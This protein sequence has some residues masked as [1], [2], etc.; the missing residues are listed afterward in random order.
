MMGKYSAISYLLR[1]EGETFVSHG[2]DHVPTLSCPRRG[3]RILGGRIGR[4]RSTRACEQAGWPRGRSTAARLVEDRGP[5]PPRTR[6][7]GG[8]GGGRVW[9]D[10]GRPRG[11][12]LVRDG[13]RALLGQSLHDDFDEWLALAGPGHAVGWSVPARRLDSFG[14]GRA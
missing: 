4:V 5:L 8:T 7:C 1:V 6:A 2:S 13:D 3:P 12:R 11:L 14:L 10:S 9:R